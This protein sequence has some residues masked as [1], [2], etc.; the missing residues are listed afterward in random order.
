MDDFVDRLSWLF[1]DE[2]FASKRAAADA[3]GIGYETYKKVA[4]GREARGLTKEHAEKIARYHR[5]SAGWLMFGEGTPE[6]EFSVPLR[7]YIGAG[8]EMIPFDDADDGRRTDALLAGPEVSAFEVRGDSMFP[9]ARDKDIAFFGP[10]RR[11]VRRMVG[12]ECAVLL[13]DGRRFFK[14][15]EAGEHSGIYDLHSYNAEPIRGVEVHEAGRFLGVRR[16]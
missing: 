15:L 3:Y 14:V 4:G 2:K 11:D 9:V 1:R 6:G 8:Q 13:E 5:V 10:P 12:Q 16:R 7:G